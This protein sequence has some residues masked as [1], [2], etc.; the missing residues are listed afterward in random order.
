MKKLI[1][2][3]GLLT[4]ASQAYAL[5]PS[6]VYEAV[7]STMTT[8]AVNVST[9]AAT[10]MDATVIGSRVMFEIQNQNTASIYCG[11]TSSSTTL[12]NSGRVIFSSGTWSANVGDA[13]GIWCISTGAAATK[14]VV[15][16]G[17]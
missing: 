10:R 6:R 8:T 15:I 4:V 17:Y 13:L 11:P 2:V 9:S 7:V 1:I 3:L 5:W 12:V 16:Q 14:A